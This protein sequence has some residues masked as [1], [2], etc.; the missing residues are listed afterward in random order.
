MLQRACTELSWLLTR[1]YGPESALRLVGDHHQLTTR[2]RLAVGRCACADRTGEDRRRRCRPLAALASRPLVID[3]YN[4][5]ITCESALAGGYLFRG[6]DGC[7]RD[8]AGVHGAWR[9]VEE[10]EKALLLIGQALEKAGSGPVTWFLDEP[11]SNSGRL[12]ALLLVT[13]EALHQPWTV[14]LVM[15]PDRAVLATGQPVVTSDSWILDQDV[16]WVN[17]MGELVPERLP[18]AALIDLGTAEA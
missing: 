16:E 1:G 12:K 6:R 8:I 9:R 15:N 14:E 7:L 11:V 5:I 4:Q 18:D 13:S 3:A 10:T 17:L 2:Q